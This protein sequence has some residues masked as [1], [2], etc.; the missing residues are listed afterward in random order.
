MNGLAQEIRDPT[1]ARKAN[2]KYMR[3]CDAACAGCKGIALFVDWKGWKWCL[4]HII[5]EI[6]YS[7][8]YKWFTVKTIRFNRHVL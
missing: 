7:E 3:S 4:K 1:E 2:R 5:R 8:N 6:R